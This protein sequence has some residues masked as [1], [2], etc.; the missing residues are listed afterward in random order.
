MLSV[1]ANVALASKTWKL[2]VP[3]DTQTP[4][5]QSTARFIYTTVAVLGQLFIAFILG[6]V[7]HSTPLLSYRMRLL[8]NALL[9]AA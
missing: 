4:E 3:D 8:R 7:A 6:L 2:Y 9:V 5:Q 1:A